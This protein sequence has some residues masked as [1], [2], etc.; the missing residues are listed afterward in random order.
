MV[1]QLKS[2][3]ILM[4][5]L[6]AFAGLRAQVTV[7]V[8]LAPPY[9]PYFSDYLTYENKTTVQLIKP[10]A[11]GPSQVYIGGKIEGDNGVSVRTKANWRPLTP[12]AL[13]T[14]ITQLNGSQIADYFAYS[15][16]EFT[17]MTAAE[18]AQNN[19]LKEGNYTLCLNVYDWNNNALVGTGCFSFPLVQPEAPKIA[20]PACES[21]VKENAQ[22][23][24]VLN[25]WPATGGA[26][27]NTRYTLT[28]AEM[29]NPAPE[30][31][32]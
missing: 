25:W 9:S 10:A 30:L 4:P 19:G 20:Q 28:I 31:Y 1:K 6:L 12:I 8:T 14:A 23:L 11:G 29:F 26:P 17:G 18:A 22:Q 13:N 21:H 32:L 7:N 2:L 27:P 5:C 15:N 3:T 16:V 24:V